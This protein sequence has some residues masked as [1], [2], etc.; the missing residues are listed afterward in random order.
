MG[1]YSICGIYWAAVCHVDSASVSL[2][3]LL[4]SNMDALCS[5]IHPPSPA[6]SQSPSASPSSCPSPA[7]PLSLRLSPPQL[8]T[9]ILHVHAIQVVRVEGIVRASEPRGSFVPDNDPAAGQWF[10][11]DV[12]ALAK[13]AGLPPETP[14]IEVGLPSPR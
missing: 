3:P 10:W 11:V 6:P 13:A 14:L 1:C 8:N 2:P 4:H 5:L 12:P 9:S 7:H